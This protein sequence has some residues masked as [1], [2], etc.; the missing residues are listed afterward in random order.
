M[1]YLCKVRILNL[2]AI[3]ISCIIITSG[4]SHTNK[5][6]VDIL[7]IYRVTLISKNDTNKFL[8]FS[9]DGFNPSLGD[10]YFIYKACD[11]ES[12]TPDN[13][14]GYIVIEKLRNQVLIARMPLQVH[15]R[16]YYRIMNEGDGFILLKK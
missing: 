13:Y 6:L 1:I 2:F 3:I 15:G 16:R 4:C 8:I 5:D 10:K 14:N 9:G 11:L 7:K 12:A